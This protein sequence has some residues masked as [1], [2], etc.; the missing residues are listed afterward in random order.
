MYSEEQHPWDVARGKTDETYNVILLIPF[1]LFELCHHG[2]NLEVIFFP[3]HII[4]V[5]VLEIAGSIF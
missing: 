4:H 1:Y 3:P 2:H 5:H